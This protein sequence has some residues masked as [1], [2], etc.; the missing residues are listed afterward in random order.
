MVTVVI[1]TYNPTS[2]APRFD[3]LRRTLESLMANVSSVEPVEFMI[4]D[5]GSPDIEPLMK[6]HE[7]YRAAILTGTHNGIG[8]SLNRARAYTVGP[9]MYTTD[10]WV[11]TGKL[12]LDLPLWLVRE[13]GYDLVRLGPLHPDLACVTKFQQ[14]H[15]WWWEM[16]PE[17]GGGFY[18]G[19][20]PFLVTPRLFDKIGPFTEGVDSYVTEIDFNTACMQGAIHGAAAH[21]HGPWETI[22]DAFP[23]GALPVVPGPAPA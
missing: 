13:R 17:I 21:L 4:A 22:G 11:L 14:H 8:A 7:E 9:W 2:D 5:D 6:L 12:D 16:T 15:G 20:R 1:T 10:D 3:Y 18:F 19:T 23:V